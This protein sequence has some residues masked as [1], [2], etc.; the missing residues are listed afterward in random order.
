MFQ[1]KQSEQKC[2]EVA[3]NTRTKRQKTC[4]CKYKNTNCDEQFES[5]YNVVQRLFQKQL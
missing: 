4:S 3:I 2:S 1:D 5:Y